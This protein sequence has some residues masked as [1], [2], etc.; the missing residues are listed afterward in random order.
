MS[1]K[2]LDRWVFGILILVGG[3]WDAQQNPQLQKWKM[4]KSVSI[5]V[6]GV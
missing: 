5:L 6:K 3:V 2:I 1:I 4:Y